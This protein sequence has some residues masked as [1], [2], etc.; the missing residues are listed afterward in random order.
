MAVE[1]AAEPGVV[2]IHLRGWDWLLAARRQLQ[3]P[4]AHIARVSTVP[5]RAAGLPGRGRGLLTNVG[6]YLPGLLYYGRFGA[7]GSR[8]FWAVR[9]QPS[10]VVIECLDWRY[11]RV[12]LGV[13][14]PEQAA[15]TVRLVAGGR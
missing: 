10:L 15:G 11:A 14:E 8:E 7:G 1:V 13:S 6:T 3:I 9:R 2:T 4:A 5:R 12:V